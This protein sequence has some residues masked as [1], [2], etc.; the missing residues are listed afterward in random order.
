MTRLLL[1]LL[2]A[3]VPLFAQLP[4]RP[5]RRVLFIGNSLTAGNDL[6]AMLCRM[7]E[8]VGTTLE[9]AAETHPN[10]ALNDH[11]RRGN[12]R[13]RVS[14]GTW[15][16]VIMQQGPSSL[17]DSRD[18]LIAWSEEWAK[19]I[20]KR[21]GRAAL[22]T[23]WPSRQRERDFARVIESYRR[24]A[25][26]SGALLIPAG[27]VWRALLERDPSIPLYGEDGFHPSPTG[28]WAAALTAYAAIFGSIPDELLDPETAGRIAGVAIDAAHLREIAAIVAS[29][30]AK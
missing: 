14:S 10:Y 29:K 20:R 6:P 4:E 2:L 16:L 17:P 23:V 19:E 3:A 1:P 5:P 18:F 9:C 11:G 13:R 7:A 28:T 25:A 8:A 12:A 26:R 24:A 30:V 15:D 21:G 22:L 27:K